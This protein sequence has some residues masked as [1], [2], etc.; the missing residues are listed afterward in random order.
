MGQTLTA[1]TQPSPAGSGCFITNTAS[2]PVKRNRLFAQSEPQVGWGLV[3]SPSQHIHT[4]QTVMY[5][6][7]EHHLDPKTSK[8]FHYLN[9]WLDYQSHL[10]RASTRTLLWSARETL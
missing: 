10:E 1:S 3:K 5:P 2:P 9:T 4:N 6:S 7:S 8:C